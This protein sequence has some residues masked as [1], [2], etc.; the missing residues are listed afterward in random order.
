MGFPFTEVRSHLH[1][2]LGSSSNTS[3]GSRIKT[4]TEA[5]LGLT[6]ASGV[7]NLTGTVIRIFRPEGTLVVSIRDPAVSVVI[8]GEDIVITGSS[9]AQR[10][11]QETYDQLPASLNVREV[12]V[13]VKEP[14]F[15]PESLVV[16]TTLLDADAYSKDDIAELYHRRWLAELDIR[17]LKIT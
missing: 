9:M 6:D 16:V 8:D 12:Q 10:M 11:D 14:G 5:D 3:A 1:G 13:Q 15:R 17:T 2:E 7:T 4:R